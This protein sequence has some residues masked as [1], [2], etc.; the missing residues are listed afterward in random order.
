MKS[1][2]ESG[3]ARLMR[4][5]K[6]PVTL[7]LHKKVHATIKRAAKVDGRPVTQFLEF[8]GLQAAERILEIQH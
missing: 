6:K 8:H 5:G 2:Q 3:G 1:K 4:S 7:G